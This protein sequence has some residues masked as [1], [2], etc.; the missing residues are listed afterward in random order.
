MAAGRESVPTARQIDRNTFRSQILRFK[1]IRGVRRKVTVRSKIFGTFSK[2]A[3]GLEA[4]EI[5]NTP[6]FI[7]QNDRFGE[8]SHVCT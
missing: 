8:V 5:L 4:L 7:H 2:K 6:L 1:A 3:T